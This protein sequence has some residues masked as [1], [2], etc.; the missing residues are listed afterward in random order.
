MICRHLL[1]AGLGILEFLLLFYSYSEHYKRAQN[2]LP[3]NNCQGNI[4]W[5]LRWEPAAGKQSLSG[6]FWGFRGTTALC[7]SSFKASIS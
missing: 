4:S 3:K 6:G 2:K 7:Y 1:F 5:K